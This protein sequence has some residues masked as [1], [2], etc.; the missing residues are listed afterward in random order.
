MVGSDAEAV[1][2]AEPFAESGSQN[3]LHEGAL[4]R[5]PGLR[6]EQDLVLSAK[7]ACAESW[8]FGSRRTFRLKVKT[9]F[10]VVVRCYFA[11]YPYRSSSS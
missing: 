5:E 8:T 9:L 3:A 7:R 10:P 11:F 4:H 6:R 1:P 2:S